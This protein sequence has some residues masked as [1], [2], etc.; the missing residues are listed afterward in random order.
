[1]RRG[2]RRR[3]RRLRLAAPKHFNRNPGRP[4]RLHNAFD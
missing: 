1:L 4:Q 2:N 3:N